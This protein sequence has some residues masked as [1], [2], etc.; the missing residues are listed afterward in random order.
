MSDDNEK[1]QKQLEVIW[2]FV[3]SAAICSAGSGP[4]RLRSP[5][6][7]VLRRRSRSPEYLNPN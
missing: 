4:G 3:C 7:T 5:D 6:L 2:Y 1:D